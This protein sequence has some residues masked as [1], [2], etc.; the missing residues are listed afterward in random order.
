MEV[1]RIVGGGA[2]K[3]DCR[4]C[5]QAMRQNNQ[6]PHELLDQ[7]DAANIATGRRWR[8]SLSSYLYLP[9]GAWFSAHC[10]CGKFAGQFSCPPPHNPSN[11]IDRLLLMAVSISGLSR[12]SLAFLYFSLSS[13]TLFQ[14]ITVPTNG[15]RRARLHHLLERP[16]G[17]RLRKPSR[18][19]GRCARHDPSERR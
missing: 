11:L 10:P 6:A 18:K 19:P 5:R 15:S 17:P 9:F 16:V 4:T 12:V 13:G 8:C 3:P 2:R 1:C 14:W 7:L